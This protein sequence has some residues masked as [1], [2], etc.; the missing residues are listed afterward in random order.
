VKWASHWLHRW[1]GNPIVRNHAPQR[2]IQNS[3]PT[4]AL[5]YVEAQPQ[6]YQVSMKDVVADLVDN[7]V[8]TRLAGRYNR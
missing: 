8:M 3:L 7:S 2:L 4:F 5:D 6:P 1:T